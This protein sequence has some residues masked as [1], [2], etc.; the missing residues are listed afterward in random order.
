MYL[1]LTEYPL[2]ISIGNNQDLY[3]YI[4]LHIRN[5]LRKTNVTVQWVENGE[6][7]LIPLKPG[8]SS[9][10]QSKILADI[11]NIIRISAFT[12]THL[13]AYVNGRLFFDLEPREDQEFVELEIEADEHYPIE[14]TTTSTTTTTTTT[15]TTV[16]PTTT[17]TT[18]TTTP[19]PPSMLHFSSLLVNSIFPVLYYRQKF[20][21]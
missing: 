8:V 16:A 15:T 13:P 11:V 18:T 6:L 19:P 1:W 9:V 14:T 4:N 12:D 5:D 7:K 21:I 3:R 17:M 2:L 10:Y 20:T